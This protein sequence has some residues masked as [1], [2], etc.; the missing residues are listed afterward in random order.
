MHYHL[1][2]AVQV[3][4]ADLDLLLA[5]RAPRPFCYRWLSPAVLHL[6][7]QMGP[8]ATTAASAV[9]W[10]CLVALYYVFR[11]Y[12]GRFMD[13]VRAAYAALSIY[14]V[15]PFVFIIPQPYTVWFPWDIPSVVFFTALLYLW[16]RQLWSGWYVVFLLGTL[17]RETTLF[18]LPLCA[19]TVRSEGYPR[20]LLG[21]LAATAVL[22]AAVKGSLAWWFK[23]HDGPLWLE[24]NHYDGAQSHWQQNLSYWSQPYLWPYLL[25]AVGFLWLLAWHL[26]RAAHPYLRQALVIVPF[27]G[28]G[29]LLFGNVVEHRVYGDLIPVV[30]AP[31]LVWA[32][33]TAGVS[34]PEAPPGT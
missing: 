18:L 13:A 34:A 30:L 7:T 22:W 20:R 12:L 8:T 31:V 5:F 28:L 3:P 2:V 25:S 15:M 24:W 9:E 19:L 14:F 33:G 10:A 23:A 16:H 29:V 4:F 11:A 26:R 32:T 6:V 27:Y 17:N 21:H 1:A